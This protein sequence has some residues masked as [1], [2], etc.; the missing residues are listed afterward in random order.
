MMRMINDG[1]G[2]EEDCAGK[3]ISNDIYTS[4]NYSQGPCE[5]LRVSK[6]LLQ[7]ARE[8]SLPGVQPI[9]VNSL[10]HNFARAEFDS[11]SFALSVQLWKLNL[12]PKGS[13]AKPKHCQGWGIFEERSFWI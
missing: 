13:K 11:K 2:L 1:L 9:C 3:P 12:K 6:I 7:I 5:L 8:S 4:I 10:K